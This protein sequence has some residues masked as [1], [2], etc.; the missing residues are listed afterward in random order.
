MT[1][2]YLVVG[3][4]SKWDRW[5]PV[6]AF[7]R[8]KLASAF[9]AEIQQ[10]NKQEID[11]FEQVLHLITTLDHWNAIAEAWNK[12]QMAHPTPNSRGSDTVFEVQPFEL[13]E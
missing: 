10:A 7:A 9:I 2:I 13:V 4:D 1:T 5:A 8:E 6:K 11:Y 12:L 3:R